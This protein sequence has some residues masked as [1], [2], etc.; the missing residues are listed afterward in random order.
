MKQLV[1]TMFIGNN[2]PSFHLW[3]KENLVKHWKVSKYYETDCSIPGNIA[4]SAV[5]IKICAIT[6]VIKNYKLIIKKN[7]DK[8]VLVAKTKLNTIELLIFKTFIQSCISHVEF[9]LVNSVLKEH[10]DKK[11]EI[12]NS[13][14]R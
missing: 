13:N 3:W 4:S 11:K 1:Y 12:K 6:A 9:V 5:Q 10:D 7:H 2:R 14:S 8:I